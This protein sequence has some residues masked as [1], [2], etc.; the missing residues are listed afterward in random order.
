[1]DAGLVVEEGPAK[2]IFSAPK[3]PRTAEFLKRVLHEDL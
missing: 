1:M 2:T 3:Q